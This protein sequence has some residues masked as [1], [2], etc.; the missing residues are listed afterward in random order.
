MWCGERGHGVGGRSQELEKA[1]G[2]ELESREKLKFKPPPP[3]PP[4]QTQ[5]HLPR[6]QRSLHHKLKFWGVRG[7]S[8]SSSSHLFSLPLPFPVAFPSSSPVAAASPGL[9][10]IFSL[11]SCISRFDLDLLQESLHLPAPVYNY[12]KGKWVVDHKKLLYYGH[13]CKQCLSS[14]WSC[15]MTQRTDFSYE[16]PPPPPPPLQTQLHLPR[17]QR[18]L[19]HK[20]KFWGVRGG[21]SS[22]SSHLFSLPLPFPVAFPSSSPVAAAS[23]GLISIFSLSSCISRFDLDLLQESLHLPAPVYNY[24]K[25]KWVVDHKKLLYYGHGCKQCL[26]SMWSCQMTQ[27]TDFSYEK[28]SWQ[29]KD[30]QMEEFEVYKFL[31]RY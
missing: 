6:P 12:A 2:G 3:P 31:K 20:L 13:G 14:M 25:G 18:S 11:S 28:V 26:S 27:R 7:G 5:L 17:P 15:Q 9:I 21:S 29:P 16:K 8:S 24:A 22:S 19:H 23:P 10:S 1:G 4:L 30:C